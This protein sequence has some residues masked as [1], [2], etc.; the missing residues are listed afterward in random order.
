MYLLLRSRRPRGAVD[1]SWPRQRGSL[2][3]K[4]RGLAPVLRYLLPPGRER[5][6]GVLNKFVA[7]PFEKTLYALRFDGRE[8]HPVTSRTPSLF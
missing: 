4:G 6:I 7:Y 8:G 2:E 3:L 1:K 5:H